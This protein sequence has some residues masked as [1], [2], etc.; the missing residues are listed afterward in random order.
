[1]K[2]K[3]LVTVLVMMIAASAFGQS[4]DRVVFLQEGTHPFTEDIFEMNTQTKAGMPYSERVINED[5][6]R[7]F[8]LGMFADVVIFLHRDRDE[9]KENNREAARNGV[10]SLLLVE[11][12]RNGKT[13]EVKVNFFPSLME[14]RTITHKYGEQDIPASMKQRPES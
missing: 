14:F 3:R 6:R 9:A 7:L 5:V 12:N 10:E 1:M 13:G 2:Y 4:I 8:A 11:K